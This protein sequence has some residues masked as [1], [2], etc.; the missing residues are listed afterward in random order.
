MH[1]PVDLGRDPVHVDVAL[2][3]AGQDVL[4]VLLHRRGRDPVGLVVGHLFLAAP[5]GLGQRALHAARHPVGIH[6]DAAFGVARGAANGLDQRGLGPQEAFLVCVQNGDQPAFGD[7][8]PLAQQVDAD[9]HVER[10]KA[11]VAQDLDPFD[12][13]DVAVHVAHADALFVHVFGQVFGHALGQRRDQRAEAPRGDLANLVQ[14]VVDLHFHRADLH[15]WVQ[16]AGRADHLFGEDATGLLQL[17]GGGGGRNEDGLRAHR[18]PFLELQGAVVHAGGQPEPVFGQRELAPVVA[19]VHAADLRDRDMAFVGEDDGVVRDE[20]EKRGGRFAGGTARQIARIV[21]DPGAGTG[22]LKHLQIEVAALFK[23][24][25]LK[26]LAFVRQLLQPLGQFDANALGRL[27]K[28][29][30]RGDIVGIGVDADL[31]ERIGPRAGQ[32]IKLGDRL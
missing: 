28:R 31:F 17:P 21:L 7:I 14:K 20:L 23:P 11:Q 8:Q 25:R 15:L 18:I 19:P 9:K 5:V 29:R 12:R 26:K 30:A 10:P 4:D 6:D 32:R 2:V 13:V 16:K 22:R 3:E 1:R 27:L 24:L